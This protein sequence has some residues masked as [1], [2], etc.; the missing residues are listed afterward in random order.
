MIEGKNITS[1]ETLTIK[2]SLK[3]ISDYEHYNLSLK[4][5]TIQGRLFSYKVSKIAAG[6]EHTCYYI[7]YR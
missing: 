4:K 6:R 1:D 3:V 7:K 5:M 2:K